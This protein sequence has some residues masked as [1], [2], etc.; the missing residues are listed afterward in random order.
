M[1]GKKKNIN[2]GYWIRNNVS[3]IER[4]AERNEYPNMIIDRTLV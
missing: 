3:A 1:L 4:K 2:L